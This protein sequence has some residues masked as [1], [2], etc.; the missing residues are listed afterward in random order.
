MCRLKG[1]KECEIS[2]TLNMSQCYV[3]VEMVDLG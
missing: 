3:A 1:M 2:L